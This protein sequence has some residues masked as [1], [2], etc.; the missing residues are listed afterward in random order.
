VAVRAD[1][2][3][4]CLQN[5]GTRFH[6][7]FHGNYFGFRRNR[8]LDSLGRLGLKLAGRAALRAYCVCGL[9]HEGLAVGAAGSRV[10]DGHRRQCIPPSLSAALADRV[11]THRQVTFAVRAKRATIA[12]PAGGAFAAEFFAAAHPVAAH[13]AAGLAFL[14]RMA[15]HAVVA[16]GTALLTNGV[17]SLAQETVAP[18]ADR[19]SSHLIA[20]QGLDQR[21]TRGASGVSD[22]Q[23]A[24]AG[25]AAQAGDGCSFLFMVVTA[26]AIIVLPAGVI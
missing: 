21:A 11:V 8:C 16:D 19:L 17:F 20:D 7:R 25:R 4:I 10:G 23:V 18:G 3:A 9:G 22:P 1:R 2:L 26:G 6:I 12:L 15:R 5:R 14:G 24:I 13:G